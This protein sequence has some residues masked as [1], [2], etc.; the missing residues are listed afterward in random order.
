MDAGIG[1]GTGSHGGRRL[2][3]TLVARVPPRRLGNGNFR[4]KIDTH[5]QAP[6]YE[7]DGFETPAKTVRRLHR[8][9]RRVICYL[10]VGSW[11]SYRPDKGQ[12]PRSVIGRKYSGFP[13]E[14][15]L[16]VSRFHRFE[17]PL[18]QRFNMCARKGFDGVE[19]DNVAGWEK[20]NHT[21]FK[22]TKADQLRFNRW[23]ARQVHGR[24]MAVALKNDGRQAGSCQRLRFRGR[25]AVLPVPRMRLLQSL[26]PPRQG[27]LR[28]R[29]RKK[30]EPILQDRPGDRLQLDP[31]GI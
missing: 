28:G 1:G 24:G 12:F 11:E 19:P 26:Y 20:E 8:Q 7:V 30:A 18:K 2:A 22:I 21:G 9:G 23:V 25:R 15:W 10:D 16:D 4:G 17:R 14:R 27:G 13:D 31:Q 6:V 5:F 3:G 29:V